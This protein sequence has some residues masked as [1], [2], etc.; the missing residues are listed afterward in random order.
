E[1]ALTPEQEALERM[2]E[3]LEDRNLEV[4]SLGREIEDWQDHWR[5]AQPRLA[6]QE[7]AIE[8]LKGELAVARST[9]AGMRRYV[10]ELR[11]QGVEMDAHFS[12]EVDAWVARFA[13]NVSRA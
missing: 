11:R 4:Q 8:E 2:A 5:L 10:G 12:D 7:A 1:S 6:E 13:G 3:A 9:V